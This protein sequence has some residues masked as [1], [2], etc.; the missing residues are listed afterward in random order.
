MKKNIPNL[1]TINHIAGSIGF[2]FAHFAS[3]KNIRAI[4]NGELLPIESFFEF[5]SFALHMVSRAS[6]YSEGEKFQDYVYGSVRKKF[7]E[8]NSDIWSEHT[9]HSYLIKYP[10]TTIGLNKFLDE[11]EIEYSTFDMLVDLQLQGLINTLK[12]VK[13]ITPSDS[14]SQEFYAISENFNLLLAS[15]DIENVI[16]LINIDD[17]SAEELVVE[18][19]KSRTGSP[20]I[21]NRKGVFEDKVVIQ[22]V[23]KGKKGSRALNFIF[24][25]SSLVILFSIFALILTLFP[26]PNKVALYTKLDSPIYVSPNRS[27]N[28]YKGGYIPVCNC[29]EI[30]CI[31]VSEELNSDGSYNLVK[32]TRSIKG[33][34]ASKNAI[35]PARGSFISP[36]LRLNKD[37]C[38]Y[39][40]F[41]SVDTGEREIL[42][43]GIMTHIQ[44]S[45]DEQEM[46]YYRKSK[47]SEVVVTGYFSRSNNANHTTDPFF[48]IVDDISKSE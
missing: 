44:L 12:P 26:P 36:V 32:M 38:I 17:K 22:A 9:N 45:L 48:F 19:S 33:L 14:A 11:R 27:V 40:N 41:Y 34:L 20:V 42:E 24:I 43:E 3:N 30:D 28:V 47:G 35:H 5:A 8:M 1:E 37:K 29:D 25:V 13:E 7:I 39:G 6:L 4:H 10:N 15:I 21:E 31:E 2:N 18:D 16:K 46:T 23:K